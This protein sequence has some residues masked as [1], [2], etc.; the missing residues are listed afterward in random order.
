MAAMLHQSQRGGG[1]FDTLSNQLKVER[2]SKPDDRAD[3][4]QIAGVGA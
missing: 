1:G 3:D 4:R 2:F